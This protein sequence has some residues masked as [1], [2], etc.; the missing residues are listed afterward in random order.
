M[1]VRELDTAVPVARDI[2]WVG[3]HD[4]DTSLHCNAYLLVDEA[5]AVLID[6]GSIPDFHVVMRKVLDVVNP[7]EITTLIASHQDPDV[8]G[9]LAV[10]EE[11]LRGELRVV[12]TTNT[13]RLIRALGLR[14]QYYDIDEHGRRLVLRSGREL[15]FI[16]TPFLHSPGAMITLD[17]KTQTAFTS[18]LFGGI[19]K[20]WSL[21]AGAGFLDAMTPFHQAYMPTNALLRACMERLE[22]REFARICPQHGSVLEGAQLQKAY[23]HLKE[24]RCGADLAEPARG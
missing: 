15:E 18:D 13:I 17:T 4:P 12:A 8:C 7:D 3:R 20:D 19:S 23:D 2:Y 21:F 5:D 6:P 10:V 24:L 1:S 11:V 14:S 9:N 16:P 22:K